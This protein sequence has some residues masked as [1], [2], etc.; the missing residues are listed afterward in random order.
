MKS[1]GALKATA[2]KQLSKKVYW[3]FV[4]GI[5]IY[6]VICLVVGIL[7]DRFSV[8]IID[9]LLTILLLVPLNLGFFY[10]ALRVREGKFHICSFLYFISRG[11]KKYIKIVLLGII[12]SL[13]INVGLMLFIVP[14]IIWALMFSQAIFIIAEKD[15][16]VFEALSE[17]K[18]LMK[19]HK[20][21][22]FGFVLSFILW[23]IL[24]IITAG[25]ANIFVL[26]YILTSY[27]NYYAELKAESEY[28]NQK[29]YV[30][31]S[32]DE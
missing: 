8:T 11:F 3:N 6:T 16:G 28:K 24:I 25:I 10:A 26:P 31:I 21:E 29:V 18:K 9:S 17:S 4:I 20:W 19:G 23:Y 7:Q 15:C 2:K 32:K 12:L 22:F 5:V 30:T 27:A 14:G 1:R 13:I